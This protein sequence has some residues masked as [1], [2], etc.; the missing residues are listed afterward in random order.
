[1]ININTRQLKK[2][3]KFKITRYGL[4]EKPEM[5]QQMSLQMHSAN[6]LTLKEGLISLGKSQTKDSLSIPAYSN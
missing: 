4:I 1:M 5:L 6:K 2:C 3:S